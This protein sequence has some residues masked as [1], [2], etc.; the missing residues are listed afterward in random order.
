MEITAVQI[1]PKLGPQNR[2]WV[3][4]KIETD[5][6]I[7]GLGEWS[8]GASPSALESVRRMLVGQ[9]PMNVNALHHSN[10]P[11]RGLWN[12]GGLGAGV[13]IALWDI[14]GKKL[15]VPLYQ[16]LGG[17]LRD[18]VR[19]YCDCHAGVFWTGGEFA[20]RWDA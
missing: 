16:L 5:E 9:D 11:H 17:K 1:T 13:E 20:R 10:Q 14:A 19:M 15:G 7:T 18:R 6:G 2:D 12:L 8:P 4:L 3:L